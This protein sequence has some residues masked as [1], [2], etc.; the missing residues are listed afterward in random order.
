MAPRRK[1][2]T[3]TR[4]KFRGIRPI[5]LGLDLYQANAITSAFTGQGIYGTFIEPF[6][7][8]YVRYSGKAGGG[9]QDNALDIKEIFDG[10]LGQGLFEPGSTYG[11]AYV[12]SGGGQPAVSVLGLGGA[13]QEHL[14]K[15]AVPAMI[16]VVGSNVA[17]KAIQKTGLS[18]SLNRITRGVGLGDLVRW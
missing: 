2:K 13:M 9:A 1:P 17:K 7:P 6:M 5:S 15:G 14:M 3:R 8:G 10:L 11:K 18:R 16:K 4:R 12:V